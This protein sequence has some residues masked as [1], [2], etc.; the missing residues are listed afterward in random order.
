MNSIAETAGKKL[1]AEGSEDG[2]ETILGVKSRKLSEEEE[3]IE[4]EKEEQ[5][6]RREE[7]RKKVLALFLQQNCEEPMT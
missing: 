2:A 7:E 1:S 6:Q 5:R 3:R 4:K